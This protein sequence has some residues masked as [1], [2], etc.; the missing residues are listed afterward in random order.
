MSDPP[1][2][3]PPDHASDEP[4]TPEPARALC[5]KKLACWLWK[6]FPDANVIG[7][8]VLA[9][10]AFLALRD[11]RESLK[12]NE[13]AWLSPSAPF[14]EGDV[15]SPLLI[16]IPFENTGN[17]AALNTVHQRGYH[18][19]DVKLDGSGIPYID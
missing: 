1:P 7:T 3:G 19:F 6:R 16:R 10:I 15:R 18:V 9:V 5:L 17:S 14:I 11:G 13:R 4:Q 12:E 8:W 2:S